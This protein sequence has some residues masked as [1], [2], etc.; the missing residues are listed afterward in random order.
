MKA[1]MT[2]SNGVD[3]KLGERH[4]SRGS[5]KALVVIS[6]AQIGADRL[7]GSVHF[8]IRCQNEC[9][10]VVFC[11][12]ESSSMRIRLC[13]FMARLSGRQVVLKGLKLLA[14]RRRCLTG[15]KRGIDCYVSSTDL[16]VQRVE[17]R[18][19]CLRQFSPLREIGYLDPALS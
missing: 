9:C 10:R 15:D 14:Q 3:G 4:A 8:G 7:Q 17:H 5:R 2:R 12:T 6:E 16:I 11:C 13:G 1:V 19:C 18:L